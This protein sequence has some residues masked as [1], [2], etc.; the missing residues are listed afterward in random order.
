M[1]HPGGL[2]R[3]GIP[4]FK[5]EKWIIDRRINLMEQE[6]II[7]VCNANVGVDI[8]INDSCANTMPSCSR[9]LHHTHEILLYRAGI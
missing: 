9:W 8:S 2:L 4:D 6:G 3:Y 7:F 1:M 5:L